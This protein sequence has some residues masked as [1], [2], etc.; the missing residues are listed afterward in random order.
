MSTAAGMGKTVNGI[1]DCPCLLSRDY[2]S[3]FTH[4]NITKYGA[5]IELD[6]VKT[7]ASDRGF[8][9]SNFI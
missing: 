3:R 6:V 9:G 7:K 1:K 8:I 2:W 5:V 4:G